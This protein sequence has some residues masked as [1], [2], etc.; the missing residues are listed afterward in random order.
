M[1]SADG[2]VDVVPYRRRPV[3]GIALGLVLDGQLTVGQAGREAVLRTGQFTFYEGSHNYRVVAAGPHSYLVV[4]IP[5]FRLGLELGDV[6]GMVATDMSPIGSPAELL[7]GTLTSLAT[8]QAALS[9]PA[10]VH[11]AD[12]V[13]ALIQAVIAERAAPS[14]QPVA[15]FN[16]LTQWIEEHLTEHPDATTLAAAH[17]LS[18]RYVRQIFATQRDNRVP[19][20]PRAPA[21]TRPGRPGEP[22]AGHARRR[23]AGAEVGLR[24]PLRVLPGL[25][26]PIRRRPTVLSPAPYRSVGRAGCAPRRTRRGDR[27]ARCDE[28]CW[29]MASLNRSRSRSNAARARCCSTVGAEAEHQPVE[30]R[31]DQIAERLVLIEPDGHER[32]PGVPPIGLQECPDMRTQLWIAPCFQDQL[33]LEHL[34]VGVVAGHVHE[35]RGEVVEA[36]APGYEVARVDAALHREFEGTRDERVARAEVVRDQPVGD[37]GLLSDGAVGQLAEAATRDD[38]DRRIEQGSPALAVCQPR[39]AAGAMRPMSWPRSCQIPRTPSAGAQTID[40]PS[41][42]DIQQNYPL[43]KAIRMDNSPVST[44]GNDS[45]RRGDDREIPVPDTLP[46]VVVGAG[47]A[48]VTAARELTRRGHRRPDPRGT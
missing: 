16:V 21:R 27:Q 17:H 5:L 18:T 22:A 24:E 45:R 3:A 8:G 43:D 19:L 13:F 23:R 14:R 26:R 35:F 4:R 28:S 30:R 40:E 2:P 46:V 42:Y 1:F 37:A 10:R 12:A 25:P 15:L 31:I 39:P 20:R 41:A 47:F 29:R 11:C 32:S 44:G 34:G 38:G 7:A 48:G 6:A 9:A 33:V 36:V